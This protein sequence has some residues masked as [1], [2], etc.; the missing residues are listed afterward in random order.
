MGSSINDDVSEDPNQMLKKTQLEQFKEDYKG[1]TITS[2]D[3]FLPPFDHHL[4]EDQVEA[5]RFQNMETM[6]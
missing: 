1:M 4:P 6:I 5:Y 3:I 2:R